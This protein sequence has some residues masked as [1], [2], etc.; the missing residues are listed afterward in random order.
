MMVT[1]A[2]FCPNLKSL[3]TKFKFYEEETLKAILISCQQLESFEVLC[4]NNIINET[5]LL[6]DIVKYSS[7]KFYEL[8]EL[9]ANRI[10]QKSLS[11]IIM[12]RFSTNLKIKKENMDIIEKFKSWV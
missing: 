5:E 1:I 7:K 11:V 8:V 4:S 3:H 12:G 6:A 2:K 10:P 9:F